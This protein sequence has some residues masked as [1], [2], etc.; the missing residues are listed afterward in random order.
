[1]NQEVTKIALFILKYNALGLI[2]PRLRR[3]LIETIA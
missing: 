2:K 3:V 1:M